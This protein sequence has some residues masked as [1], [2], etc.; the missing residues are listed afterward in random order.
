MSADIKRRSFGLFSTLF[1][2]LSL[3]VSSQVSGQSAIGQCTGIGEENN[4]KI[5]FER[6][7]L[8]PAYRVY[9]DGVE[10]DTILPPTDFTSDD[11]PFV[12][13]TKSYT[14]TLKN[15]IDPNDSLQYIVH[16]VLCTDID[17]D[18][19]MD[20]NTTDCDYTKPLNTGGAIVSTVAPF[21]SDHV[22]LYVLTDSSGA[23]VSTPTTNYS[24]HFEGLSDGEYRVSAYHFLDT[25]DAQG[26]VND[27]LSGVGDIDDFT[28]M[29][30]PVCYNFCGDM[31][32]TVDCACIVNI[33]EHPDDY[34]TCA[35]DSAAFYVETSLTETVANSELTYHWEESTDNGSTFDTIPM[36]KD[37]ILSIDPVAAADSGYQYRVIVTL[38]VNSVI[39]CRD[40][41]TAGI[42]H[43]DPLPI[44][45]DDLDVTVCSDEATGITLAV[46]PSSVPATDYNI[47]SIDSMT[48]T[49]SAGSPATGITADVSEIADD[50]WTNTSGAAVTVTY[51]VA[52]RSTDG[53]VGDTVAIEVVVDPAP[54]YAGPV[55]EIVCSDEA[56]G[57]VIPDT[58]DFSNAMDSF[59]VSAVVGSNLTGTPTEGATVDTNF[60]MS[61]IFNNVSGLVDSVTYTV[62]PY[63]GGCAGEDFNIYAVINPEPVFAEDIIA[64]V[65][66]DVA[67]G[68]NIPFTDDN[69][70]G[71]D[72]VDIVVV[73]GDSLTGTS[74]VGVGVT[75]ITSTTYIA[76][77]EFTN[78]SEGVDSVVYT[79]TPYSEGCEGTTYDIIVRVTP[80]PVGSD[81]E[82]M[83]CSDEP[84]TIDLSTLIT[85]GAS[86][87]SFTWVA[88]ANDTVIGESTT[89]QQTS[90]ISQT[91]TDTF[92]F[93]TTV[94]YTVTPQ[95][96]SGSSG[97]IG[98]PFTV[99]V[100]VKPEPLADDETD[101]VCSEEP[102]DIVLTDNIKQGLTVKGFIYTVDNGAGTARTD[103]SAGNL[104]DTISNTSGS[105][106]T[107]TYTVTPI[108]NDDC[109][110]DEFTVT[111]T[112]KPEPI[113]A[114]DL[115][116][117]VCSNSDIGVVLDVEGGSV[118]A[119]SFNIVSITPETELTADAGNISIGTYAAADTISGDM[120]TNVDSVSHTVTYQV[121]PISAS[122]CIGD[123]ISIVVTIDPEPVVDA[124]TDETICSNGSVDLSSKG[125]ISGAVKTGT[126]ST[127]G[128]GAFDSSGFGSA[129]S[130]TPGAGDIAAG[131]VTL[132]LTSTAPEGSCPSEDDSVT[133]T[134]NDVE[135]SQFPWDGN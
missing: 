68:E 24:G 114:T 73:I 90:I 97:C 105:D 37:S 36:E 98:D 14:L 17:D 89:L 91:L 93:A 86:V 118:G 84:F 61:D 79:I 38:E 7:P 126:W 41:S 55:T 34:T 56:I 80:E 51:Q 108:S 48:L 59:L 9:I 44:L 25:I 116:D 111:V 134:I 74:I 43:V 110:G 50:A 121:A 45:A 112:I 49:S 29:S 33:D 10:V 23:F 78:T 47:V 30:N 1:V 57:I 115:D 4:F 113:M 125:S 6:G 107:V 15:L 96:T 19:T 88:T 46:G 71:I 35:N 130:Y 81:P 26:F 133:I 18:G 2:V 52:P 65:C 11:I 124:G 58:D 85:N 132:T 32:Y 20:F 122:G 54:V 60:I 64:S 66:S 101:M 72:S 94:I 77:D 103:T 28:S 31:N 119:D 128:D 40:T 12:D 99:T 5:F 104:R 100:V 16:E 129:T 82:L 76:S 22:Y 53:C 120:Y 135:C 8:L 83:V 27:S 87:D 131:S 13:G 21:A 123:T 70:L 109:P 62:T 39:I 3:M 63:S 42:L 67:I 95:S 127:S 69:S 92:G 106:L 117:T 75:G 102:I